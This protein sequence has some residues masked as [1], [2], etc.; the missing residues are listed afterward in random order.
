[1]T[2]D[3]PNFDTLL[4]LAQNNPDELEKLRN[5]LADQIISSASQ[6]VYQRLLGLQFQINSTRRLSKTPLAAC[7]RISEMMQQSFDELREALNK[8]APPT[9]NPVRSQTASTRTL[10][11]TSSAFPAIPD[12]ATYTPKKYLIY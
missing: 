6:S 12:I 7:I 11:L 5:E 3:M 9:A 4:E 8:P 10:A 1:M 2:P